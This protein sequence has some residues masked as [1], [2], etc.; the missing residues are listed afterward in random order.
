MVTD[1]QLTVSKAIQRRTGRTFHI[2]T[3]LLPKDIR[4]ATYVL[5]AFFRIADQVVDDPDPLPPAQQ[6]AELTHIREAALG[7]VSTDDAVL[8]AFA[9]VRER[10]D[11][12]REEVSTFIAAMEADVSAEPDDTVSV[13]FEDDEQ[14]DE[15]LRGSAVA[16]GY[17]MLALMEPDDPEAARPH[18]RALAEAFQLTNFLRDVREDLEL[19]RRIYLPKTTLDRCNATVDDL[20]D[21]RS[22]PAIR[23]AIRYELERTEE[24]YRMGVAGIKQLPQGCQFAVLLAA[25]FY[26]EYHR[27]IRKQRYEVLEARPAITLPRYL[28]LIARTAWHWYRTDD[29]ETTFYRVSPVAPPTDDDIATKQSKLWRP[30]HRVRKHLRWGWFE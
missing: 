20:L 23:Q 6:L 12:P 22:T 14:R 7:N 19:Y 30:V 13:A 18:A 15:Y 28:L 11:I 29:P 2:A 25:V 3:R 10:Y 8:A 17:M 16:V 4:Q 1:D 9:K 26:S 21:R 27:L 24:R 5:Y